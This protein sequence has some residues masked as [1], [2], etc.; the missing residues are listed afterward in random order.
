MTAKF[1]I[2]SVRL[3]GANGRYQNGKRNF[4]FKFNDGRN[5]AAKDEFGH[6]YP[7]KWASMS[8]AKGQSNRET[9]T[10][11]LNENL[12]YLL[13]NKVGVPAPNS[14]YFHWRVVRSALE[15]RVPVGFYG[16]SW[17]Q[18]DYDANFLEAHHLAKGN[19]YKLINAARASDPYL[20]MVEQRRYRAR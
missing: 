5:F 3:R 2:T 15:A 12:N 6:A 18:E 8:S 1:T 17:V 10:F 9:V 11:A 14:H 16:L 4:R 20:D 19:L 7:R 13:M